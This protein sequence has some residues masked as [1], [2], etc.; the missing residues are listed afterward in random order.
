VR[1]RRSSASREEFG[2]ESSAK[3]LGGKALS[4]SFLGLNFVMQGSVRGRRVGQQT[5]GRVIPSRQGCAMFIQFLPSMA[6]PG[7][8]D[9]NESFGS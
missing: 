8:S 7:S 1:N 6:E 9:R 4:L 3:L 5:R 2:A